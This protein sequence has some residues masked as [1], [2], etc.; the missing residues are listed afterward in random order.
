MPCKALCFPPAD[1]VATVAL[2]WPFS[3]LVRY[4]K[5]ILNYILTEKLAP[6]LLDCT[7][8]IQTEYE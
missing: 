2:M 4:F 5:K 6:L 8:I 3:H 7:F 1:L